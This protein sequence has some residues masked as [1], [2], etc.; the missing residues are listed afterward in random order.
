MEGEKPSR[1]WPQGILFGLLLLGLYWLYGWR[2]F[3]VNPGSLVDDG[4]YIRNAEAFLD[5]LQGRTP[6]WLGPYDCFSLAKAPLYGLWLAFLHLVGMPLR[7]G[8]FLLLLAGPFLFKSA[9]RP[10]TKLAGWKFAVVTVLLVANAGLPEEFRLVRDGLQVALSNLCLVAALGLALRTEELL[11]ERMRWA[12]TTGVF[13]GLC[14]L[15]REEA[16]W[17]SVAVFVAIALM[18]VRALLRWRQRRQAL[19]STVRAQGIVLLVLGVGFLLPVLTVCALN[20]KHYG[21]FLTTFRRSSAF[22]GLFQRLTSLE[23]KGRQ[24]YVPIARATRLK[25]YELSPTFARL[26]P[27]LEEPGGYWTAGNSEH[28]VFNG[29]SP[30]DQE[31]FVS[32]FEFCLLNATQ[33]AGAKTAGQ[34]EA[35]FRAIDLE[36]GA[37]VRAGR[38]QA[39][40]HGPAILAAPLPGDFKKILRAG[41]LSFLTL[42]RVN[43]DLSTWPETVQTSQARL[44]DVARLTHSSV[45]LYPKLKGQ[46]SARRSVFGWIVGIQRLLFP[47]LFVVPFA[48]LAWKRKEV[49]TSAPSTR[50][51]FLWSMAIPLS[52]LAAFCA[53]MGVVEVLGFRFLHL[54]AYNILGFAPLSVLCA[55]AFTG[56]IVSV[57]GTS[58]L[59]LLQGSALQPQ[60]PQ[61]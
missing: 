51:F 54:A 29:R 25:A 52:G 32:Y 16:T 50:G 56:L 30:A 49:F 57:S 1:S 53:S 44:D 17:V 39:G 19:L 61:G 31:F 60:E 4:L 9:V 46:F 37:A 48:L 11:G 33:R 41:V 8:E 45:A 38:I 43:R 24:A 18:L 26:K 36:L 58:V 12:S 3:L 55:C 5:W 6:F 40:S 13:L 59:L 14:Y 7:V 42:I 15:N 2:P 35:M 22:T 28:A 10:V 21:A 27:F 20:K 34:M 23:P 47:T